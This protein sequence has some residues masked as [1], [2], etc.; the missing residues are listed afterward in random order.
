M[1]EAWGPLLWYWVSSLILAV[2]L[3]FPAS[4]VVWVMRVRRMERRLKRTTTDEERMRE[5][6]ES[7]LIAG[8]IVITFSFLFNRT[9]FPY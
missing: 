8:V 2:L 9:I 1:S 4:R 3:Y 5:R 7:N 6:R